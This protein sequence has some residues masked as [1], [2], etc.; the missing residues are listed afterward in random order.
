MVAGP[1]RSQCCNPT[2]HLE[3]HQNFG[4]TPFTAF[5]QQQRAKRAPPTACRAAAAA[6]HAGSNFFRPGAVAPL[7][8]QA[9]ALPKRLSGASALDEAGRE[10]ARACLQPRSSGLCRAWLCASRL[11][12]P[13]GGCLHDAPCR[14]G[15]RR[16]CRRLLRTAHA[17]P[18]VRGLEW[19]MPP[20]ALFALSCLQAAC[21]GHAA[22]TAPCSAWQ[23]REGGPRG[24]VR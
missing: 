7:L 10:A 23:R 9:G 16:C 5:I 21:A 24:L 17:A 3:A 20:R 18:A 12:L 19:R 2:R 8:Y 6:A 13:R 22:G 11:L 1:A 4:L 14:A 15:L